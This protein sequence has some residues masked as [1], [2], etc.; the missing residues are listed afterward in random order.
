MS[1]INQFL[2][3]I[4]LRGKIKVLTGLHI[5]GSK[6]KFEIGGVDNPVIRDTFTK[7]PYIPGSS[8]KGKMRMLL[9][10]SLSF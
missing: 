3:N 10:C 5:G 1:N 2:A 4:I 6:D 9:E 8:L 7:Y